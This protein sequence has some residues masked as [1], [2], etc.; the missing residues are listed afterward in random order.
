[1]RTIN[2]CRSPLFYRQSTERSQQIS[3]IVILQII[4]MHQPYY[5]I[6]KLR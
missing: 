5:N 2:Y 6:G 4:I 3:T 1:M